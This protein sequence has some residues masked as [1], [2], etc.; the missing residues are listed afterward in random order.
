MTEDTSPQAVEN[1]SKIE[2]MQELSRYDDTD[3]SHSRARALATELARRDADAR[4]DTALAPRQRRWPP[5]KRR[6]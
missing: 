1:M 6:S 3:Q 2:L 4:V 5:R